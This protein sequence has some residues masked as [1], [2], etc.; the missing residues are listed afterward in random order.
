MLCSPLRG[1]TRCRSHIMVGR[2]V[3]KKAAA[4][5]TV[6]KTTGK[7]SAKSSASAPKAAPKK[8]CTELSLVSATPAQQHVVDD[9]RQAKRSRHLSRKTTEG[10]V[11][12]IIKSK[13]S[14]YDSVE[15]E[16]AIG[17]TTKM[18]VAD[19]IADGVRKNRGGNQ[20]L[21]SRFWT[22][23]HQE[24]DL[25][26][27][28]FGNMQ[29]EDDAEGD[30]SVS[31]EILECLLQAHSENPAARKPDALLSYLEYVGKCN[32]TELKVM[33]NAS[34]E[35]HIVSRRS[36]EKMLMGLLKFIGKHKL[37]EQWKNFWAIV[38]VDFDVTFSS[39]VAG[40]MS[41]SAFRP[42]F[43]RGH[44][45]ALAPF[46]AMEDLEAVQK[47]LEEGNPV[48]A[49]PLQAIMQT[50]VGSVLFKAEAVKLQYNMFVNTIE[51][52]LDTLEFHNYEASELQSFKT[53][54]MGE[55]RNVVQGAPPFSKKLTKLS[56][57]GRETVVSI[58]AVHDEWNYRLEA[59]MRTLA[60]S[61]GQL[62]RLPW[63]VVL[64]GEK[65]KVEG[66][67]ETIVLEQSYLE[68]AKNVRKVAF[69]LLEG[70]TETLTFSEMKKV[71]NS[72]RETLLSLD[73]MFSLELQ[74]LN[75]VAEPAA[76]AMVRDVVL[77]T[78]PS[79]E[80]FEGFT[81]AK[82]LAE[83]DKL[84]GER[85]VGACSMA[86]HREVT[87]IRQLIGTMQEGRSPT[88]QQVLR[89]SDYFRLV[90][91]R[92]EHFLQ[93]EARCKEEGSFF[94]VVKMVSGREAM[95]VLWAAFE[96]KPEN[97]R[98][99][100]DVGDF[101][102]HGWMLDSAKLAIVNGVISKGIRSYQEQYAMGGAS[103]CDNKGEAGGSGGAASSSSSPVASH[104]LAKSFLPP[105]PKGGK[106][107][108]EESKAETVAAQKQRLLQMF[109]K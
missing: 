99:L 49:R 47:A 79:N 45:S 18:S 5:P 35:S 39:Y 104:E 21:N 60:V 66:A 30:E 83:L 8:Q 84:M 17:K 69:K 105:P 93:V 20:Y 6:K 76:E 68:S 86:L 41:S 28:R 88:D 98:G 97:S 29:S 72:Q 37:H 24:F 87:A 33:I 11:D 31:D 90:L 51:E 40:H 56:F 46:M 23:F 55:A 13:L 15:L 61:T 53:V 65:G 101:R 27:Q 81:F 7:V 67:P 94:P 48:P 100:A 107:N 77:R 71:M 12:R 78:M 19:F 36:S 70:Y 10:Q 9:S 103:I 96:A 57:L 95:A 85:L 22:S 58:N 26:A 59:R 38:S 52:R 14:S 92:C 91:G 1:S 109:K 43:I 4:K 75:E 16:T 89:M 102:R 106:A 32:L 42:E 80:C 64:L 74:W 25:G 73:R 2:G 34:K 108:K 44:A 3:A 63:E 82:T 54:V 62:P 50:G